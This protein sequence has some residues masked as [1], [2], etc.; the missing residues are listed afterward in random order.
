MSPGQKPPGAKAWHMQVEKPQIGD[1]TNPNASIV[2]G[3]KNKATNCK[4][5]EDPF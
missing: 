5:E 4:P 2:P 1:N 3:E